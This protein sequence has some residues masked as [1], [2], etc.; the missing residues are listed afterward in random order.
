MNIKKTK[1]QKNKKTK[2]IRRQFVY[3]RPFFCEKKEEKNE[4]K[5]DVFFSFKKIYY[6]KL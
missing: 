3:K 6:S 2:I 4:N 1:K 5:I